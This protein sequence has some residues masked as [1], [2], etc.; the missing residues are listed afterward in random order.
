[1][2]RTARLTRKDRN[3]L[4]ERLVSAYANAARICYNGDMMRGFSNAP[5]ALMVL[6][7]WLRDAAW[8][9]LSRM[10]TPERLDR[11]DGTQGCSDVVRQVMVAACSHHKSLCQLLDWDER[12]PQI[13]GYH[14]GDSQN[15]KVLQ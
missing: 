13:D 3:D 15:A 8:E 12:Y 7:D 2:L 14:Y 5:H 4:M 6:G 10:M 1:M 9:Q 11:F